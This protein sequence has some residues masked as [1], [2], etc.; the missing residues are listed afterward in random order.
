[1]VILFAGGITNNYDSDLR[2]SE[3]LYY[4]KALL[5]LADH[6]RIVIIIIVITALASFYW[7]KY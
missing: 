2:S 6:T 1:M 4:D 5:F 3:G 7:R